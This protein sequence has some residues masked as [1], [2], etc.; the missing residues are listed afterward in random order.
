MA[1][2]LKV[3]FGLATCERGLHELNESKL[4][5]VETRMRF[6][7]DQFRAN[8]TE[9]MVLKY[10]FQLYEIVMMIWWEMGKILQQKKMKKKAKIFSCQVIY[11]ATFTLMQTQSIKSSGKKCGCRAVKSLIHRIVIFFVS[12]FWPKTQQIESCFIN[13]TFSCGNGRQFV[14]KIRKILLLSFLFFISEVYKF[15]RPSLQR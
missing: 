13:S 15:I 1:Q 8:Y 7:L 12:L 10:I 9:L 11:N 2:E 3:A 14:K 5:L 6:S 4:A